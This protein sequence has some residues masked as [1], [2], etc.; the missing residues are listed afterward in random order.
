[1]TTTTYF[2]SFH[3]RDFRGF[4][5]DPTTNQSVA[6]PVVWLE[7]NGTEISQSDPSTIIYKYVT[8]IL[9]DGFW[10]RVFMQVTFPGPENTTLTLTTETL[11]LP[12]T[13]PVGPC[14]DEECYGKLV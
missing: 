8:A 2:L 1:M 3:R 4:K 10:D 12:D 7:M 13:C 6:N 9:P 14:T 11:I 5:L